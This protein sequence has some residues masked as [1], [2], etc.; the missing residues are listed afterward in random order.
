MICGIHLRA[1][2]QEELMNIVYNMYSE[3][4]LLKW[5]PCLQGANELIYYIYSWLDP[6]KQTSLKILIW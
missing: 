1:V 3:I 6:M 4:T 5:Q 2:S